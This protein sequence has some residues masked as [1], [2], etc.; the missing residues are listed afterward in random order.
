MK[1]TL[2]GDG[3]QPHGHDV[4]WNRTLCRGC[5]AFTHAWMTSVLEA[6]LRRLAQ[7]VVRQLFVRLAEPA[8]TQGDL[9]PDVSPV[10]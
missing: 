8:S 3:I 6:Q 9:Y 4:P 10:Q 7:P 2:A 1:E 5:T